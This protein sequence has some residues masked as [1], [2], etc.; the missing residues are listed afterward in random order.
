MSSGNWVLPCP[1]DLLLCHFKVEQRGVRR[2]AVGE[3]LDGSHFRGADGGRAVGQV[4]DIAVPMEGRE[5][6]R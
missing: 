2:F 1:C 4:V 6:F 5:G 3:A